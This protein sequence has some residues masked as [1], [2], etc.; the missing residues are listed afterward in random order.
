MQYTFPW[1][2]MTK[3]LGVNL[4]LLQDADGQFASAEPL[5]EPLTR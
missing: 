2:D 3:F 1:H 4:Q 5:D